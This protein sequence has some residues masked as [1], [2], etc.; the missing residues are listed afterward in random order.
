MKSLKIL[1]EQQFFIFIIFQLFAML[2]LYEQ[3]SLL[4]NTKNKCFNKLFIGLW[5]FESRESLKS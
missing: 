3:S 4:N 5:L 1:Y 2:Y